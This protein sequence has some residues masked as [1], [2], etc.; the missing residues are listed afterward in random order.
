MHPALRSITL[1]L[2]VSLT[3][4]TVVPYPPPMLVPTDLRRPLPRSTDVSLAGS[5]LVGGPMPNWLGGPLLGGLTRTFANR[6]S[7]GVHAGT[8][9]E[10]PLYG[11]S[12]AGPLTDASGWTVDWVGGLGGAYQWGPRSYCPEPRLNNEPCPVRPI[13]GLL[14]YLTF[15]PHAGLRGSWQASP[16]WSLGAAMRLSY[17]RTLILQNVGD[18]PNADAFWLELML[19]AHFSPIPSLRVGFGLAGY[20]L[21]ENPGIPVPAAT[22]SVSWSFDAKE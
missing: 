20:E 9:L 18:I 22:L 15:A 4:C 6:L 12:L 19:G 3:A 21:L 8:G 1:V 14:H 7:L 17:S 2:A 11:L 16:R 10:G 5:M 13:S